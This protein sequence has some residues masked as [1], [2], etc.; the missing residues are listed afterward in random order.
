MSTVRA[1]A[2]AGSF[3]SADPH[4]LAREVDRFLEAAACNDPC[5]KAVIAPHAGHVYSGAIAASAYARIKNGAKQIR[6]VVLLGPSHRVAFEGIATTSADHYAS[7]LG[8]IPIDKN[9]VAAISKLPAVSILDQAH[10]SGEHSIEVHLPFLQRCLGEFTLLPLVVG[11]ASPEQVA[12]VLDSQWGGPD[13]LVVISSDLSHHLPY[14]EARRKDGAT[15][16][17]IEALHSNLVGDQACGCRPINGL[18][19]LLREKGMQIKTL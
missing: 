1:P 15:T 10:D 12:A 7:P 5:P 17:K 16:L 6:K 2:V 18:L 14:D 3:Y 19:H 8:K 11:Q 4:Q 13:T 9:G